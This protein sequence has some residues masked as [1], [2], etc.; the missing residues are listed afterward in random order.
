MRSAVARAFGKP[1]VIKDRPDT[2]DE[3]LN[4]TANAR[5]VLAP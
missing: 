4:G 3:L 2:I 1:P 5:L